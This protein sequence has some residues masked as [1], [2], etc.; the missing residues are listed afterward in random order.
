MKHTIEFPEKPTPTGVTLKLTM[1][2]FDELY[3]IVKDASYKRWTPW[4]RSLDLPVVT[5]ITDI[6]NEIESVKLYGTQTIPTESS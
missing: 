1:R 3:D 4:Y 6:H 5:R 2:E